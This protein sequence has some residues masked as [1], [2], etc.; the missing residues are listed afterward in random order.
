MTVTVPDSAAHVAGIPTMPMTGKPGKVWVSMPPN[1]SEGHMSD[2]RP[3][4]FCGEAAEWGE[5]CTD[6]RRSA[7]S[8]KVKRKTS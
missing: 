8:S 6:C 7:K 4:R 3:C 5:C 2:W 1:H